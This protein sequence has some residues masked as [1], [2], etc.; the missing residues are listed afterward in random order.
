MIKRMGRGIQFQTSYTY[1]KCIDYGSAG[2]IDNFLN[3]GASGTVS[4]E[5]SLFPN[6]YR[7]GLCDFDVRQIFVGNVVWML[8]NLHSSSSFVSHALGGWELNGIF[9]A[10]S[11]SPFTPGIGGAP[12]GSNTPASRPD[13][14]MGGG[15]DNPVNPQNANQYIKVNCFTPPVVPSSL[16]GSLPFQC[17]PAKAAVGIPN[18]CMN[19][20]GNV[21][22][23]SVIGPGLEDF[24]AALIKNTYIAKVSETFNVQF[25]V[26]MF[27]VF[28]RAN[29]QA[30]NPNDGNSIVL[31]STG[32]VAGTGGVL[33]STVTPSRQLQLAL[34]IIW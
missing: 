4:G 29:F 30:P 32:T 31:T 1:S 10:S 2:A 26:E 13:R 12:L 24:D 11:G 15:C 9:S 17:V 22:R 8:P 28:N 16:V 21:G 27:N 6:L 5:L 34:K 7:R 23:N 25:R 20:F 19:L 3:S 18:T 33:V 14:L